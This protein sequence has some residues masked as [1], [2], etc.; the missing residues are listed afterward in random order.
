MALLMR[1]TASGWSSSTHNRDTHP[2]NSHLVSRRRLGQVLSKLVDGTIGCFRHGDTTSLDVLSPGGHIVEMP[3][4]R[5]E[6]LHYGALSFKPGSEARMLVL[7]GATGVGA[8]G[9]KEQ[10]QTYLVDA[11]V[12]TMKPFGPVGLRPGDGS[13]SWLSNGSL[14][15]YLPVGAAGGDP[16]VYLISKGGSTNRVFASGTPVGVLN[17]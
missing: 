14:I 4:S 6:F 8:D 17:G 15:A 11:S 9:A 1:K 5:P 16:G 2:V 3:L 12:R 7:G 10:Y 13:W